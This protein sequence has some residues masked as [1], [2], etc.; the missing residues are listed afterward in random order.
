MDDDDAL[1]QDLRRRYGIDMATLEAMYRDW[2]D[3]KIP[4]SVV[5]ARY[6]RTRRNHGKLFY[7]LV[8]D[9]LKIETQEAHPL[10]RRIDDLTE[11]CA[12]LRRENEALRS[13][14]KTHGLDPGQQVEQLL[15]WGP[16][17]LATEAD[18]D[19]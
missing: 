4:K 18:P 15:A 7:R 2:R 12:D 6:L 16:D 3:N 10:K 19:G 13:M 11:E 5:E 8:R 9:Y 14:L 1:E 17:E